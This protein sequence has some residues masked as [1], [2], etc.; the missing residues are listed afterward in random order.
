MEGF[1]SRA[2]T[3]DNEPRR[4]EQ[5]R[6]I[7]EEIKNSIPLSDNMIALEYGCGTGLLSFFLQP[8][9]KK[10]LLCDSSKGMLE[11]VKRKIE[12]NEIKNMVTKKLDLTEDD[13]LVERYDV[14]YTL[15][16]LH[17]IIDYEKLIESFML[18][19][20]PNGYLCIADLDKEDGTFHGEGFVGHNGFDKFEL[21]KI[22]EKYNFTN[23]KS[24]ICYEIEKEDKKGIKRKY[25]MFLLTGGKKVNK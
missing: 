11:V 10:I 22:L 2:K 23:I 1:D 19:L 14:I 25:P 13:L 15:M 5:A 20:N 3:W 12:E 17:H 7:S 18:M 6:I 4:I 16:T 24:R 8:Y 9:F 21:S